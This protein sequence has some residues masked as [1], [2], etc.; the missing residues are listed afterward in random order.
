MK[1]AFAVW[2]NRIAPVFDVTRR[3]IIVDSE[4]KGPAAQTQAT[5]PDDLP[6][7]KALQLSQLGADK[8]VCGAISRA[9][10]AMLTARGIR[11]IPFVA[12]DVQ[13]IINAWNR[14]NFDQSAFA[15]PG[16]RRHGSR[17]STDPKQ[18]EARTLNDKPSGSRGQGKHG[19]QGRRG[20]GAQRTNQFS[21]EALGNC[22]CLKC[23]H[24][25]SH[26]RGIP[27]LQK[28]CPQCGALMTRQ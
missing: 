14:Q 25:E 7:Q 9:L 28:K 5:L 2:N 4:S 8:L 21:A 23:G 20:Q 17:R 11:V 13:E 16:C 1:T 27:C 22:V 19:G 15:M 24:T 3:V 18:K 10:Q 26:E 6:L 12:G